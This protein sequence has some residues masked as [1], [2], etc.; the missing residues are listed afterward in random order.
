MS[1]LFG[2]LNK[3][4]GE[5]VRVD[6]PSKNPYPKTVVECLD[7]EM[8]YRSGTG[9]AI[10]AFRA[11]N[12]YRGT[13]EEIQVKY[14]TLN[15]ALAKVYEIPEPKLVFVDKI[16][17]GP[18]CLRSKPAVILIEPNADGEYSVVVFLHE[19]AHTLGHGEVGACKWSLN[20]FKRYWPKS[21]EKLDHRGHMLY[22]K[23]KA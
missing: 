19:F 13:P 10:E 21:F 14:R 20:L 5:L 12:P 11:M 3:L 18:C 4:F 17:C 8:K 15:T 2:K 6:E 7:D 22:K 16:P 1:K 23:A 9:K